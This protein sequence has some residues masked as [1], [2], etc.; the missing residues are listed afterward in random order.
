MQGAQPYLPPNY[1]MT[2]ENL[3]AQ[4]ATATDPEEKATLFNTLAWQLIDIN[5]RESIALGQKALALAGNNRTEGSPQLEMAQ[6]WLNIGAGYVRLAEYQTAMPFLADAAAAFETLGKNEGLIQATN[7]IGIVF[8]HV[9]DY[10]SFI[11][12]A[13]QALA[14]CNVSGN[15]KLEVVLL[16]NIGHGYLR[17]SKYD[18][19]LPYLKQSLALAEELGITTSQGDAHDNLCGTLR[20]MG[21]YEAAVEHG[22]FSIA[23]YEQA[24]KLAGQ[25]EAWNSLGDVYLDMGEFDGAV[26]SFRH[27]YQIAEKVGLRFQAVEA[28]LRLGE[29]WYGQK[30][31]T[32][33]KE[34]G[35]DALMQA[36]HIAS[37][38]LQYQ[39]HFLLY[40][41]AQAMGDLAEALA[42]HIQYHTFR[43][44]VF[45]QEAD[46]RKSALEAVYQVRQAQQET[47]IYQ[48]KSVELEREVAERNRIAAELQQQNDELQAFAH[49]VAHDLKSPIALMVGFAEL[50]QEDVT[51]LAPDMMAQIVQSIASGGHKAAQIIDELLLLA[52][53]RS[54]QVI[55]ELV[56]ITAVTAD[57][58]YHL[59][60]EIEA[61]QGTIVQPNAFPT[62]LGYAPWIEQV[63]KNYISN[64]LKYGGT[65]PEL[66]LGFTENVAGMT[67]F[68][69]QDNG[70]GLT[71]AEQARVFTEFTRLAHDRA[72]GHGL[73]LAIV[74]RIVE[75]LNGRVGVESIPGEGCLFYFDLPGTSG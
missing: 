39:S 52:G 48:L 69:V 40:K 17:Q 5:P 50:L 33:A 15:K 22:R 75:K 28:Q 16:N 55:P 57:A 4:L 70:S 21:D 25:A 1:S 36:N 47:E 65:P 19:A 56:D 6:S 10:A 30:Q 51:A 34:A 3:R 67:R 23:L 24:E 62:A 71:P 18:K 41:A 7:G 68:W 58:I 13:F 64:G 31:Y 14:L 2:I 43:E 54:Q 53:V 49:T 46:A 8:L 35:M 11:Q 73:G 61:R 74:R 29:A 42:H 12:Y 38:S 20:G 44:V 66:T 37:P 59:Q 27:S 26:A 72:K 32:N 60:P 63:W 45:N 9:G